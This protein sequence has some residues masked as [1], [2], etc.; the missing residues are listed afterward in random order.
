MKLASKCPSRSTEST[1]ATPAAR[2]QPAKRPARNRAAPPKKIS[3]QTIP[4]T[5]RSP[6]NG[7]NLTR[8]TC[9][10]PHRKHGCELKTVCADCRAG[11][12]ENCVD[13]C[14]FAALPLHPPNADENSISAGDRG[15]PQRASG[16]GSC[17]Q[18]PLCRKNRKR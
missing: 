2:R 3:P 12:V 8:K 4:S 14:V 16:A 7:G 6:R 11:Y 18:N 15:D 17:A 13:S 9:W 1:S 10:T 5:S